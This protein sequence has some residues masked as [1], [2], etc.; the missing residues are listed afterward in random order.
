[1][2]FPGTIVGID[3]KDDEENQRE[4]VLVEL[5]TA[6]SDGTVEIAFDDRNERCYLRFRLQD[7]VE[8]AMLYGRASE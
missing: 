5:T 6:E 3:K 8:Q 2:K 4:D 1:M 7:L